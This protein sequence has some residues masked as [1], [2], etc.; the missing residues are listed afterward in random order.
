MANP[1]E[2]VKSD[3]ANSDE[4]DAISDSQVLNCFNKLRHLENRP[5]LTSLP[6]DIAKLKQTQ[7]FEWV[8]R[9][10]LEQDIHDQLKETAAS[11][12]L[13][14]NDQIILNKTEAAAFKLFRKMGL[15]DT[16]PIYLHKH[17]IHEE[18]LSFY[19]PRGIKP[20][21]VFI[22]DSPARCIGTPT[23]SLALKHFTATH[24]LNS[25]KSDCIMAYAETPHPPEFKQNFKFPPEKPRELTP[26]GTLTESIDEYEQLKIQIDNLQKEVKTYKDKEKT[27]HL[28]PK[29]NKDIS[30]IMSS[31]IKQIESI[32]QK[33]TD[34]PIDNAEWE[35]VKEAIGPE[36]SLDL[37]FTLER[38]TN[39][40][41]KTMP[42][43]PEN[44]PLLKPNMIQ[45]TIGSFNPEIEELNDFKGIWDSIIDHTKDYEIYEHEYICL[46]KMV[47]KGSAASTLR[48]IIR[49]YKG[50]L[51]DILTA[52][53]DMYVPEHTFF[54]DYV[55]INNFGRLPKETIRATIRRASFAINPLKKTVPAVAWNNKRDTMLITVLKQVIDHR[56]ATHLKREEYKCRQNNTIL[57][58]ESMINIVSLYEV[59][60]D[61]IP[62][63]AIKLQFNVNTMSLIQPIHVNKSEIEVLKEK[64]EALTVKSL[65]PKRPRIDTPMDTR[66]PPL[67]PTRR[68]LK[69]SQSEGSNRP[70]QNIS[71][72]SSNGRPQQLALQHNPSQRK[73]IPS[74]PSSQLSKSSGSSYIRPYQTP[75]PPPKALTY[76]PSN[77]NT[78]DKRSQ[79]R[80]QTPNNSLSG[81]SNFNFNKSPYRSS[82]RYNSGRYRNN[83]SNSSSYRN[84]RGNYK[85]NYRG[86]GQYRGR[87][88]TYRFS[89]GR[90]D[91]TLHF[92]KCSTCP[93][94]HPEGARC[95]AEQ[96]KTIS[97]HPNS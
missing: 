25:G 39:I 77:Q 72:S 50:C 45:L 4:P 26:M 76:N 88:K 6:E 2:S 36:Q 54:D 28:K 10:T 89:R 60:H 33:E 29:T 1:N 30:K 96:G 70:S 91:V 31:V 79:Y 66:P 22:T 64:V 55:D 42:R 24:C 84:N 27:L 7:K 92:Y 46:L 15:E 8:R 53:Q 47:M 40:I 16:T 82:Q 3:D 69:R 19:Y 81:S 32:K 48:L 49:E 65:V 75:P 43:Y 44:L 73:S 71:S 94:M 83:S 5:P 41:A 23:Y 68:G 14:Y 18:D 34:L 87:S 57:D 35:E 52:I 38:P 17:A 93:D 37:M 13:P 95:E 56:T 12:N 11:Q 78:P 90:N 74:T 21:P 61:L 62:K 80:P 97:F 9:M 86:R 59:A 67:N 85:N 58:I 20:N 63:S 51:D